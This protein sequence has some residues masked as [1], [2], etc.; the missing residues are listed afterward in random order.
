MTSTWNRSMGLCDSY[1]ATT[2]HIGL[3]NLSIV[4]TGNHF[5]ISL[6]DSL[7]TA[8]VEHSYLMYNVCVCVCVFS[9][10][11]GIILNRVTP[12]R[13]YSL[14]WRIETS[15]FYIHV[16]WWPPWDKTIKKWQKNGTTHKLLY[17]ATVVITITMIATDNSKI[18]KCVT[19]S[20]Y[21]SYRITIPR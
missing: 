1:A 10:I 4:W 6:R 13:H 2:L 12:P 3:S 16:C 15:P 20:S 11:P 9:A 17:K 14:L 7:N 21:D 19:M 8:R 5:R 18:L